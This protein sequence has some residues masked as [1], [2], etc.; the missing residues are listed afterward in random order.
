MK[1]IDTGYK[2]YKEW[3][4]LT[5]E[6][7]QKILKARQRKANRKQ[8]DENKRNVEQAREGEMNKCIRRTPTKADDEDNNNLFFDAT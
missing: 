1:N 3:Q 4:K 2:N 5:A 8:D 6:Q 7:G